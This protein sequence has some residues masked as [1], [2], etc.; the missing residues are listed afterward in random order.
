[1]KIS[2]ILVV[3]VLIFAVFKASKTHFVCPKCGES[4]KVGVFKY[5]FALHLMGKRMAKCPKCGHSELLAPKW[6]KE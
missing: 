2:W 6:D 1:M 5:I 4:F 3:V